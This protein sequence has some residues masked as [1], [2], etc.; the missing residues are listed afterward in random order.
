MPELSNHMLAMAADASEM[1][2]TFL[3][4]IVILAFGVLMM[5]CVML[6]LKRPPDE[7]AQ[8]E[9]GGSPAKSGRY[10]QH[11]SRLLRAIRAIN[12]VII[13]DRQVEQMLLK[14]CRTLTETRGYK[15]A[16]IGLLEPD[17]KRVR[18]VAQAGFGEGYLEQ[19]EV[20]WDDSPTG[21]GPTGQAIKT[22][23]P[24]VMRDI[25]VAPEYQPWRKQALE[26]GYRSSAALP[27]RFENRVL[28]ALCVYSEI[29]NAFDIEEIGLLQEVSDHLAYAL[30][31]IR[32]QEQLM[33][34]RKRLEQLRPLQ[35][36]FEHAPFG[37]VATDAQGAITGLNPRAEELLRGQLQNGATPVGERLQRFDFFSTAQAQ[38]QV[39]RL[40]SRPAPVRFEQS[41]GE[42]R[43]L[44]RGVP[45]YQRD[46]V[47]SGTLWTIENAAD[48]A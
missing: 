48:L 18:P 23:A 1:K 25:E 21:R 10:L 36:A 5:I 26:R 2:I 15:M 27:L 16:W 45:L 11:L 43:L 28:G 42:H 34:D 33:A 4:A 41:A 22:S 44:C 7:M 39:E 17:S 32:L 24:A 13:S 30:G 8:W 38:P 37:I 40:F 6:L 14:A 35:T 9:A 3:W 12:N 47:L 20:T 31:T 29:P 19:I 46:G